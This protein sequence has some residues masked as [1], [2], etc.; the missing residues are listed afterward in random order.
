V[1]NF[2]GALLGQAFNASDSRSFFST[3]RA[4]YDSAVIARTVA[5]YS[6][7]IGYQHWWTSELRSTIDYSLLKVEM[8]SALMQASGRSVNQKDLSMM[9]LNL[10]WSPVAF[11]DFGIEGAWGRRITVANTSGNAYTLQSSLKFRF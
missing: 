6:P 2:G 10:I 4:L 1:T 5:S 11:V 3:N 9:H 8:D 7:R